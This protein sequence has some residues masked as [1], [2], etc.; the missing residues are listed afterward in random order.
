MNMKTGVLNVLP[1]NALITT[2]FELNV[3]YGALNRPI[4]I[5]EAE[6]GNT[7]PSQSYWRI[8][9]LFYSGVTRRH[10][11]SRWANGSNEFKYVANNRESYTYGNA[12]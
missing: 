9:R 5:C 3:Y 11:F 8:Q 10:T 2:T 7:D 1:D 4:Y 6:P 12:S